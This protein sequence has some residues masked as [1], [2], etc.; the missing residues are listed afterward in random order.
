MLLSLER[1]RGHQSR[2]LLGRNRSPNALRLRL[3]AS[4]GL[5]PV[6]ALWALICAGSK[7]RQSPSRVKAGFDN[8][9]LGR[10]KRRMYN[11][12]LWSGSA[13]ASAHHKLPCVLPRL[14]PCNTSRAFQASLFKGHVT[15]TAGDFPQLKLT[16]SQCLHASVQSTLK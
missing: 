4:L 15:Q 3:T 6:H 8:I 2:V 5:V 9:V 1:K 11:I 7:Q 14:A 13:L 10:H 16:V 12:N